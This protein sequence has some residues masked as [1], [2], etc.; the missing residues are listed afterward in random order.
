ML[1]DR[2]MFALACFS[3]ASN[4][5]LT[6]V[7]WSR[8]AQEPLLGLGARERQRE[9]ER[10]RETQSDTRSHYFYNYIQVGK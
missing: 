10:E 7:C 8:D 3:P 9:R 2:G 5:R 1:K 4:M 6:T